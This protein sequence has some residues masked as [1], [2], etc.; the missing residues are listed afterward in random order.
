MPKSYGTEMEPPLVAIL[1]CLLM[2][3]II[4]L[5]DTEQQLNEYFAG[6]CT[7]FDLPLAAHGTEF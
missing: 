7:D 6:K 3:S 5:D 2:S 4:V 1:T